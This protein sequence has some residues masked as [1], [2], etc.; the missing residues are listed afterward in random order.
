MVPALAFM[1]EGTLSE[2]FEVDDRL[3]PVLDFFEDTFNGR[4]TSRNGSLPQKDVNI[5]QLKDVLKQES[6]NA[7]KRGRCT[8]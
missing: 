5:A 4:P 2:E 6:F 3:T 8:A 1:P 7:N